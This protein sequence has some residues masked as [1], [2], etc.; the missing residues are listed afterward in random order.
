MQ[1]LIDAAKAVNRKLCNDAS[2]ELVELD[3]AIA[4]AE[5]QAQDDAEVVTEW[6]FNNH[7]GGHVQLTETRFISWD[8]D[9]LKLY[10][11]DGIILL[12]DTKTRGQLRRLIEALKGGEA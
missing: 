1:R 7:F 10:C 11:E 12:N 4:D 9:G 8:T 6:W 2:S 3:A 5:Q